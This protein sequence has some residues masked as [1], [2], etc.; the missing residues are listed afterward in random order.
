VGYFNALRR[1]E[2]RKGESGDNVE[3]EKK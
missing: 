1:K 2:K 3:K